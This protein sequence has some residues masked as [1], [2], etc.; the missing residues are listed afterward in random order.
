MLIYPMIL[1]PAEEGGFVVT[2][3]DVPDAITQGDDE[4]E[5]LLMAKDAL[6]TMFEAYM[7]DWQAIP[8]PSPLKGRPGVILPVIVAS[9]VA[10]YNAMCAKGIRK[11]DLA[12][13]LNVA[14]IL[15]DRLLSLHHKS[16]IEQIETALTMLGQRL[17][18]DVREAA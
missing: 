7:D 12:R 18:V 17:V 10:L 1:H 6:L 5:A 4:A 9:K 15:V 8:K 14:S 16:R 11:T 13:Q 3:P 2:F